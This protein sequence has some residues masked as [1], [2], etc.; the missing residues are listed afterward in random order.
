M[1]PGFRGCAEGADSFA[2]VGNSIN[3]ITI[4]PST[5]ENNHMVLGNARGMDFSGIARPI[6]TFRTISFFIL[7]EWIHAEWYGPTLSTLLYRRIALLLY[8]WN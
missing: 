5:F 8:K 6:D 1:N 3:R 2:A 7:R 4:C